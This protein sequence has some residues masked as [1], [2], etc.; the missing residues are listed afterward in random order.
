MEKYSAEPM[1]FDG[2]RTE[3]DVRQ[4]GRGLEMKASLGASFMPV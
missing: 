3:E 4:L 1:K 2:S